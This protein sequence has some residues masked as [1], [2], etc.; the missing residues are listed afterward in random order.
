M[1]RVRKLESFDAPELAPYKSLRQQRDHFDQRI[2]V[3]EGEKVVR[4]FLESD[5]AVVSALMP[6]KWFFALRP[7]LEARP[8]PDLPVY[9]AEKEVLEQLVGFSMYQGVLAVGKVPRTP[10]LATVLT[11]SPK[12]HLL[13][14]ADEL[15][16]SEN[17]GVLV[18]NCAAFGVQALIVGETCTSPFLRRSVR[19]SMGT[20]FKLPVVEAASLAEALR[21]LRARGVRCLAAHPHGRQ[22]TLYEADFTPDTCLV[23]GSE[24]LGIRPQVLA[25]CDEAVAIPMHAGVDS[26]NVGCASAAFLAEASRQRWAGRPAAAA[27][28]PPA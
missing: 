22:R 11:L 5:F 10:T 12:P 7:L 3:A 24:G 13:V 1:I 8:E 14:A 6:E 23:F 28:V 26:L 4:R 21:E 18:R 2:F 15:N 16:N 27:A 9:L 19:A 25:A 17:M 20:I